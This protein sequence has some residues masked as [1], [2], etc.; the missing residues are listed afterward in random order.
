MRPHLFDLFLRVLGRI[1]VRE[2]THG[3]W[4]SLSRQ[5]RELCVQFLVGKGRKSAAGVVKKQDLLRPQNSRRNDKLRP[6]LRP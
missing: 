3:D 5:F 1:L 6:A 2:E 4:R